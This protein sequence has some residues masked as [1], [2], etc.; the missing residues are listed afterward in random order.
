[1]TLTLSLSIPIPYY[2]PGR[3]YNHQLL[4]YGVNV[5]SIGYGLDRCLVAAIIS[6]R[7][8]PASAVWETIHEGGIKQPGS[9]WGC[10]RKSLRRGGGLCERPRRRRKAHSTR[11]QHQPLHCELW[12]GRHTLAGGEPVTQC[13]AYGGLPLPLSRTSPL[14]ISEHLGE[15]SDFLVA[16]LLPWAPF[17]PAGEWSLRDY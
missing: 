1:M 13:N 15:G 14:L 11:P 10:V 7:S 5:L 17:L 4:I 8:F 6:G 9:W 3:S 16:G 2:L 12:G